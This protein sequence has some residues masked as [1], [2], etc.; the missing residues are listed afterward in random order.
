[1]P[2]NMIVPRLVNQSAKLLQRWQTMRVGLK[3]LQGVMHLVQSLIDIFVFVVV[4]GI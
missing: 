2:S 3:V 4:R 1:M